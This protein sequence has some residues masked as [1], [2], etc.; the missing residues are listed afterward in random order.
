MSTELEQHFEARSLDDGQEAV[1]IRFRF[2]AE[3]YVV[4]EEEKSDKYKSRHERTDRW[5]ER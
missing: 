5:T 3:K 4:N 2:R 1:W